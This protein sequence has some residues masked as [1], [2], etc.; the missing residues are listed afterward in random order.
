MENTHVTKKRASNNR[1]P[2]ELAL[3]GIRTSKK[4]Q[5]NTKEARRRKKKHVEATTSTESRKK[6]EQNLYENSN[7]TESRKM[8]CHIQEN[9][10]FIE[11]DQR[12]QGKERW[13]ER[14]LGWTQE[15]KGQ[16]SLN[17]VKVAKN[18][19]NS[20]PNGNSSSK[21]APHGKLRANASKLT[22]NFRNENLVPR[23]SPNALQT[24]E[25]TTKIWN[26]WQKTRILKSTQKS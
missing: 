14:V 2:A 25:R 10:L 1:K 16:I 12:I 19:H 17:R 15:I 6:H 18:S 8:S 21:Q 22:S 24:Q 20:K 26:N 5:R 13:I 11:T 4:G 23:I 9:I 7:S 3:I